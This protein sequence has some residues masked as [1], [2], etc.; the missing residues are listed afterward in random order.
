[1]ISTLVV[2][3]GEMDADT[4][5]AL[6]DA[7]FS[8]V[9]HVVRLREGVDTGHTVEMRVRTIETALAGGLEVQYLIEPLG[10]EH[11]PAEILTEARRAKSI[12]VSGTAR[13]GPGFSHGHT[14]GTSGTG[15]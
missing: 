15:L 6:K 14:T 7:G 5:K 9:Y 2:N 8:M 1:M 11:S 3:T 4:V 10:P 12:G 13:H